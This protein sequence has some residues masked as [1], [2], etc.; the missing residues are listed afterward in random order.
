MIQKMTAIKGISLQFM[1][2]K[3][4]GHKTPCD[5]GDW[6]Y[7][8][9]TAVENWFSLFLSHMLIYCIRADV[10][11]YFACLPKYQF[12]RFTAVLPQTTKSSYCFQKVHPRHHCSQIPCTNLTALVAKRS[13]CSQAISQWHAP[14]QW[15]NKGC[16]L[17]LV[18]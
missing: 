14:N 5:S 4:W 9:I 18:A 11:S 3:K 15:G 6:H 7:Q 16:S 13:I 8:F 17:D 12:G 10:L 2:I 1:N